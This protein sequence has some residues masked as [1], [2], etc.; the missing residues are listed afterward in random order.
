MFSKGGIKED[1]LDITIKNNPDHFLSPNDWDMVSKARCGKISVNEYKTW[2]LNLIRARW[3]TRQE[4][5]KELAKE[6][7][8]RDIKLLC[9]C[10][11]TS[12]FCHAKMAADFMNALAKKMQALG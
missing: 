1:G 8:T 11:K 4:E 6:G 5:F 12:P 2:Y 7:L 9:F 3:V 10:P